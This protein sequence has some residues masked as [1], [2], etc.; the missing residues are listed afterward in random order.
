MKLFHGKFDWVIVAAK[1]KGVSFAVTDSAMCSEYAVAVESS[2]AARSP[3][4]IERTAWDG[5]PPVQCSINH[6]EVH[7]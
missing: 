3:T 6:V 2:P 7:A 5:I 4:T 1:K